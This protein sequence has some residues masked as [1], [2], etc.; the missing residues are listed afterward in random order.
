[1]GIRNDALGIFWQDEIKVRLPAAE[2][3]KRLPPERVWE[4]PEYLPDLE[5]ALAFVPCC[6][7]DYELGVAAT[8]K[9]YLLFDT[10]VYPNYVLFAFRG[11]T[12]KK[13]VYFELD[14]EPL[15]RGINI[16]KLRYIFQNFCII[17]FNGLKY[18]FVIAALALAE[19]ST[20]DMWLATQMLIE[21]GVNAGNVLRHFKIPKLQKI[22]QI[23]LIN[24]TALAPGLKVCAGRLHANKM[25]D[26]PFVPGTNLHEQQ[27]AIL[28]MYCFND[29]DNTELLYL[30]LTEQ[31]K[32]RE[33]T[34]AKYG[35]DLRSHSDQ[36]MAEAI[37]GSQIKKITGRKRLTPTLLPAGTN[38]RFKTAPFIKFYTPLMNSV[39]DK[40]Q[41]GVY[42]VSEQDGNII[43]PKE[44]TDTTVDIA[45]GRYQMGVGGLHSGE[46]CIAHIANDDYF[47]ADTDATSYYPRLII[48]AGI[49]PQNLG[50][51]FLM[52]YEGIVV[53]RI[54]AKRAG[55]VIVAECLKIVVNGTFGKLGSKYSII[56]A[57]DL[58]MQVTITGQLSLLMLAERFELSDIQ[59]ISANTDGIVVRCLRA[60]EH[61][62][63]AI[64]K[65]WEQE[66]G[67]TTEEM[68]YKAV[69]SRDVNNYIAQ[70][71][72]PQK[73]KQFK[74]KGA[75]GETAPKKN[76]VNEIC[77]D[78]VTQLILHGIPVATTIQGCKQISKF[79]TMRRAAGGAVKDG[80][81][82]GKIIRWYYSRE[83][84]GEIIYAKNGNK[85]ARSDGARPCMN[86]PSELPED[87]DYDWYMKEAYE[88]L[89]DIGHT[90]HN[91][92]IAA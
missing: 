88:I 25:Q 50:Q 34:G 52:V 10:E 76:A 28:F 37:I 32:V 49:S 14:N 65:Q 79:T 13:V 30:N 82:L 27:I 67:F 18:D 36:Q 20:A 12:S 58:M 15:G 86:L 40:V 48:N 45:L 83:A 92:P 16:G 56:Y 55:Q 89:Q 22:N 33:D 71:E 73:G 87:I 66:T 6:Y 4:Q 57:P 24:L 51:D 44:I 17:N 54:D 91:T 53:A 11:L 43:M 29:L 7:T 26:L 38:Y 59:V 69:Y 3:V 72:T 41:N 9:E 64:V 42:Y 84:Q 74:L 46:K 21:Q 61:L 1:M 77:V 19:V 8:Q 47:I 80:V 90:P 85:V 63:N 78:A 81:Y 60:K 5:Q 39:L 35:L 2:K 70:Y 75:Y 68:R 62:F 23:D 31:I